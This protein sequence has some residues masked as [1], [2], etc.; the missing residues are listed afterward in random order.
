MKQPPFPWLPGWA[1][2]GAWR[3][4]VAKRALPRPPFP[5]LGDQ[6]LLPVVGSG[7]P[8]SSPVSASS[9]SGA[10]GDRDDQVGPAPA[11]H[12]LAPAMGAVV[13]SVLLLVPLVAEGPVD[14]LATR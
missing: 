5:P 1:M 6:Y 11:V 7:R 9:I 13:G 12:R 4:A 2:R 10:K 3:V 14:R 8:E